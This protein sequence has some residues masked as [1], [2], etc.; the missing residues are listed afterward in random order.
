MKAIVYTGPGQVSLVEDW[1]EP[2]CGPDEV[3]V[4]MRAVGLC[5]SDLSVYDGHREVP[6]M[7][8]VMGHEGGGDLAAVGPRATGRQVGQRVVIEPNYACLACPA[9]RSGVTSDCTRR[10]IVGMNHPGILAER[11]AVPAQFA[12]PVPQSWP[13][14]V[15]ASFEP[16]AVARAAVRRSGVG[17]GQPCLVIGAGSQGLFV[18]LSLLAIGARPHVMDPHEGRV[19]LAEKIGAQRA[20]LHEGGFP[21]V[22][23][24]AG[25]PAA[26]ATAMRSVA[27][28]GTVTLIGL[29]Q[30]PV[31]LST[32]DVVRRGLR[33][34]GSIIY[35]HPRDF[36]E[37]RAALAADEIRPQG[38]THAGVP[39][40]EAA[41]AFAT[42]RGVPG[43]SW[44]DLTQW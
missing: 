42:A 21:F 24:T 18:C 40:G 12:W 39:P 44:I 11:V 34:V 22:F 28:T 26:F 2:R 20:D 7:P 36:A 17:P 15:L 30:E 37:T 9:C 23:E 38:A 27:S 5:G 14:E 10:R 3:I 19:A 35:D 25:P 1:P 43:K 6:S 31:E 16:L 32:S 8:W 41:E 4:A 29:G 13:G 33:I